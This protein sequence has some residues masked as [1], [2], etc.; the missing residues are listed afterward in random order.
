MRKDFAKCLSGGSSRKRDW[1]STKSG[2]LKRK[3]AI[4]T[5]VFSTED[6]DEY[7]LY[8][9]EKFK[10]TEPTPFK[11]GKGGFHRPNITF[12]PLNNFIQSRVGHHWNDVYSE[13]CKA[14][15]KKKEINWYIHNL[16]GYNIYNIGL[17]KEGDIYLQTIRGERY[18]SRYQCIRDSDYIIDKNGILRSAKDYSEKLSTLARAKL[19]MR[20]LD[21]LYKND[22]DGYY[23]EEIHEDYIE[24][25]T[26]SRLYRRPSVTITVTKRVPMECFQVTG[27][28]DYVVY[29]NVWNAEKK[30]YDKV[31]K[32]LDNLQKIKIPIFGN[33]FY[34]HL[35]EPVYL[36]SCT[37][38]WN[39]RRMHYKGLT[40]NRLYPVTL[41]FK[42]KHN[43]DKVGYTITN[44]VANWKTSFSY[45][46]IHISNIYTKFWEEYRDT[47]NKIEEAT[48]QLN[49]LY[50]ELV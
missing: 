45:S 16:F 21:H 19:R 49:E 1:S 34:N 3:S 11:N 29:N 18:Y 20:Q 8:P 25:Y 2:R 4:R 42:V 9:E 7:T 10:N 22:L 50:E 28:K 27:E 13:I 32:K 6:I 26:F 36:I 30:Q 43:S 40:D 38:E 44:P 5:K 23:Y 17:D 12:A 33:P 46:K 47:E 24:K 31:E 39:Y 41:H 14:M 37:D 48:A 35:D 15:P